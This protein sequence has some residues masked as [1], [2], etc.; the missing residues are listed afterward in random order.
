[1]TTGW[2]LNFEVAF[3][4]DPGDVPGP[5]DWTDLSSR[6]RGFTGSYGR[7]R[8]TSG[9]GS[10]TVLLGNQDGLLDPATSTFYNLVP[11]RH[12]R[13]TLTIGVTTLPVFRGF[14]EGWSPVWPDPLAQ[15]DVEVRLVDAFAW[16]A[17]QDADLDRP[18]EM[19]DVRVGAL[20]DASGWPSGLRDIQAGTVWADPYVQASGNLYRVLGDTADLEDGSLWVAP[21]GKVT[22]RNRHDRLD[23]ASTVTLGVGG[24]A[25]ASADPAY[26][27]TWLTNIARVELADGD[28]FEAVDTASVAAYGPRVFPVR[29]LPLDA[30]SSTA[31]AQWVVLRFA[32]PVMWLDQADLPDRRDG[33]LA[34]TVS[35]PVGTRVTFSRVT[36]GGATFS[37]TGHVERVSYRAT[38]ATWDT[39]WE[40]SPYFGTGPWLRWDDE[41]TGFW[42][43]GNRWMP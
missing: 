31:L 7:S 2:T 17:L 38:A 10:A 23:V 18:R 36:P 41:T 33:T 16:L 12:A 21:D 26:D 22:F 20:L 14:V 19:S 6:I 24:L 28:T 9:E 40:L 8:L 3:D 13:A 35:T 5:S 39:T 43:E 1:V 11:M 30:T 27:S 25:V 37:F 42:D 4:V 29:D 32:E 34:T 15:A